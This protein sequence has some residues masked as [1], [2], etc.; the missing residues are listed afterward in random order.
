MSRKFSILSLLA[1]VLM[2]TALT[3][4]M[5]QVQA[6][7]DTV[8]LTFAHWGSTG[9]VD[10]YTRRL[11]LMHEVYPNI[12]VEIIYIPSDYDQK[13]LTMI[14]G[15]TPP[16]IM[17][18]AEGVHAFSDRGQ[19]VALNDY[20]DQVGLD[21]EARFGSLAQ[22]YMRNG[23]VFA[24]PDRGGAMIMYYNRN[25]FDAAGVAYPTEAWTW[26]DMLAAAQA[27]T[28]SDG[29][30]VTQWGFAAGGWWPWWMS[31]LYQNGGSILDGR[32][33]VVNSPENIEAMQFYVDL[34][35]KYNVAPTPEDYANAGLSFGQPDPLFSQ[36]KVAFELTGFWLIGSLQNIPELNWDIAPVW[37]QKQRATAAF[38]SGLAIAKDCKNQDAAFQVIE[39]LTSKE[40]QLP[41]VELGQDAPVN[42][43][44]LNSEAWLS[45]EYINA[46]IT[47][48]TFAESAPAIFT[49]PIE[50]EWNEIQQIFDDNLGEVWLGTR[51]VTDA[52]DQI[53]MDLEFLMES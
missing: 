19:L 8:K 35:Y 39:F 11:E 38:G 12:D 32:T 16:D 31:F 5:G 22:T 20:A 1:V 28:L 9:D 52:L 41:I 49:P 23:E 7:D 21:L 43:D 45:G 40:G 27:T 26:D 53:Q 37:Q 25:M 47:M 50:P 33:P 15:G 34:M 46:D 30:T 44:L 4:Y 24:L 36:G 14:A 10:V 13:V 2:V 18:V 51:S 17:Q 29:D 42:L 3:P 48:S 6:Q